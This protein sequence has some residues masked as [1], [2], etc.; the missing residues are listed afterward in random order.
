MYYLM[1]EKTNVYTDERQMQIEE[2]A[3]MLLLCYACYSCDGDFSFI[4]E[5]FDL[6]DKW[7]AYLCRGG[8]EYGRQ[9]CTDDF[10]GHLDGNMNLS[11]KA[12]SALE[13]YA[14]ILTKK[15]FFSRAE[16]VRKVIEKHKKIIESKRLSDGRLP[17]AFGTG[18][19]TFSLK[20]NLAFD[21]IFG[22]N[23]FE[24]DLAEA[25]TAYYAQKTAKYGAPLD[26][27]LQTTKADWLLWCVALNPDSIFAEKT[28]KAV[29]RFLA[30]GNEKYP[31][32]DW[33]DTV[34]ATA[35]E[36]RNRTVTGGLFMPLLGDKID[37]R[38]I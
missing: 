38:N 27:R 15:E 18:E 22:L 14:R 31:F 20:Y 23:V 29:C 33:Y 30:D 21:K 8:P 12:T 17:L 37:K 13:A 4:D 5:H 36:F 28:I 24:S 7:G 25:E 3:N 26:S 34:T 6:L 2:S 16:R 10:A 32:P 35:K 11:I 9:L 1:G 19:D